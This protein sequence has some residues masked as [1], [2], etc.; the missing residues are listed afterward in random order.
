MLYTE[1]LIRSSPSQITNIIDSRARPFYRKPEKPFLC[2]SVR[3][4]DTREKSLRTRKRNQGAGSREPRGR[5][6]VSSCARARCTLV[7]ARRCR[8]GAPRR[9]RTHVAESASGF[10]LASAGAA[11]ARPCAPSRWPL[12]YGRAHG[13]ASSAGVCTSTHSS[14]AAAGEAAGEAAGAAGGAAGGGKGAPCRAASSSGPESAHAATC[15]QRSS[16][17]AALASRRS[18]A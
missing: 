5:S 7:A 10:G 11:R 1:T 12:P 15:R 4:V 18:C 8:R 3:S 2:F 16:G 14:S 13:A 6:C 9:E 17:A